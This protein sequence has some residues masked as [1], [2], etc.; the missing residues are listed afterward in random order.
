MCCHDDDDYYF[1]FFFAAAPPFFFFFPFLF[2]MRHFMPRY[3][4]TAERRSCTHTVTKAN[5]ADDDAGGR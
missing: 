1:F 3:L 2:C 4:H 5:D